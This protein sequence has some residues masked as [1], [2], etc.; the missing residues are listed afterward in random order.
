M[1]ATP[2]STPRVW[3]LYGDVESPSKSSQVKFRGSDNDGCDKAACQGSR[4]DRISD[5]VD[6]GKTGF[7]GCC[8]SSVGFDIDQGLGDFLFLLYWSGETEQR[9]RTTCIL[10]EVYRTRVR[11]S[12]P[13]RKSRL[14]QWTEGN[15]AQKLKWKWS[16]TLILAATPCIS[17]SCPQA[18]PTLVSSLRRLQRRFS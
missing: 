11:G 10:S 15:W 2:H 3:I 4:Q 16:T 12:S 7:V 9:P 1:C 17:P 6:D 8:Q 5:G 13:G 18:S 14:G